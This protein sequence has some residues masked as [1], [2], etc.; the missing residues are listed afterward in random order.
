MS[1]LFVLIIW[2]INASSMKHG[3]LALVR[4]AFARYVL[5]L[6]YIF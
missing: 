6:C 1:Q 4:P 3:K 5:F 2:E